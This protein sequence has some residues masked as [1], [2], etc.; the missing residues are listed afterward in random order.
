MNITDKTL[1]RRHFHQDPHLYAY[2][3]GDLEPAMW[4]LSTFFGE[5]GENGAISS[6]GLVWQG[7]NPPVLLLF[8]LPSPTFYD[9]FP[10]RVFYM[11]PDEL[12]S[13]F[14]QVYETPHNIPLWRMKV[15]PNEFQPVANPPAGL[16]R[17]SSTD[18]GLVQQLFEQ[19]G[20]RPEE[21]EAISASQIDSGV[22]FGI[23]EN[24]QLVA[25][26][27]SHICSPSESVGAVGYVYTRQQVRGLGYATATTA[28][29]TQTFFEMG[30]NTVILNVA[31]HNT[32]AIRAYEKLGYTIHA[33]LA[34]GYGNRWTT[35]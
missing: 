17:L 14:Q 15:L 30:I 35:N 20:P 25:V 29:V 21:I 23:V 16:Q 19:D 1:L 2:A 27:G 4:S 11:L 33:A 28:A 34:E 26:A 3:L 6:L 8:G 13:D 32:P 18:M 7:V 12:L 9:N 31:R 22:F 5:M 24:K 10:Q